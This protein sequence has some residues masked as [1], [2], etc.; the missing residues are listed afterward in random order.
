MEK[1]VQRLQTL[2]NAKPHVCCY[3]IIEH[4]DDKFIDGLCQGAYKILEG[5]IAVSSKQYSKLKP[6]RGNLSKLASKRTG[7]KK[8]KQILQEGGFLPALI[9][10]I[11]ASLLLS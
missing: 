2:A 5:D 11:L 1:Y 10:P 4:A 8:R 7:K 9:A 3:H 6:Y